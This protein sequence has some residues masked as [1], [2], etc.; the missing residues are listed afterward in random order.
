M[1]PGSDRKN[2]VVRQWAKRG[3]RRASP[4]TSATRTPIS[5]AP[6]ARSAD[7][8][9]VGAAFCLHRNYAASSGR[10][11][12][13][14]RQRRACGADHGPHRLTHHRK[15]QS[16]EE[17]HPDLPALARA[18]VEAGRE[19]L[20]ASARQLALKPRLRR[21]RCYHR[22]H[23]PGMAKPARPARHHHINRH[24]RMGARRSIIMPVGMR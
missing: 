10:N 11:Q 5:S 2:G 3:T 16:A 22:R 23:M 9:G 8:C 7:R 1:R 12:P 19:C 17:H 24:A 6:S 4:P 21:L 18:G 15:A 13:P 20:A 14:C